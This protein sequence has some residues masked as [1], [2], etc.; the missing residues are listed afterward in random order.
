MLRRG[1]LLRTSRYARARGY[2]EH[3]PDPDAVRQ[4]QAKEAQRREQAEKGYKW[5]APP[6]PP[7]ECESMVMNR[8]D[9]TA[10]FFQRRIEHAVQQGKITPE[11]AEYF[12]KIQKMVPELYEL[13]HD[14]REGVQAANPATGNPDELSSYQ[15]QSIVEKITMKGAGLTAQMAQNTIQDRQ[16]AELIQ[17]KESTGKNYWM[18]AGDA[19]M[20]TGLPPDM[21]DE[22]WEDMKGDRGRLEKE[23]KEDDERKMREA[24]ERMVPGD[25]N[26]PMETGVPGQS[27]SG[28]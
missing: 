16:E 5:G 21:K 12:L 19:L 8:D 11:S 25:Y 13:S 17:R 4:Q 1:G 26:N 22:V 20:S 23:I 10:V 3:T 27:P 15:Q 28:F 7:P 14:A 24:Q 2:V 9:Q 6:P 18:E